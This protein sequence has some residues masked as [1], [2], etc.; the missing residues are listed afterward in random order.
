MELHY[1]YYLHKHLHHPTL[2]IELKG[3]PEEHGR[4][5]AYRQ[6]MAAINES[7]VSNNQINIPI[8]VFKSDLFS[9]RSEINFSGIRCCRE[10]LGAC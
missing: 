1:R 5:S 8:H 10:E 9:S 3:L 7:D 6:R 4:S 2:L